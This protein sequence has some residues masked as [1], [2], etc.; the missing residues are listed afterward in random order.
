MSIF[1]LNSSW[2]KYRGK[3]HAKIASR[4]FARILVAHTVMVAMVKWKA[5]GLYYKHDIRYGQEVANQLIE[6]LHTKDTIY[7]CVQCVQLIMTAAEIL[8]LM[9][10]NACS[11]KLA[12]QILKLALLVLYMHCL[13]M[14]ILDRGKVGGYSVA[15]PA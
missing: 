11:T 15:T 1:N 13:R 5:W 8:Q 10:R 2:L 6:F 12:P 9:T 7:S 14:S 3:W 4:M